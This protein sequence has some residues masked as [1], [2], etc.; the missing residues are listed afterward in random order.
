MWWHKLLAFIIRDY[1][2]E[3]SYRLAFVMRFAGIFISIATFFFIAQLFGEETIP[4]LEAY[5][6][7]Y[8][9][10]VLIGIAFSGL[11]TVGLS[12]FS[13]SIS[14]AQAQGTL[15]AM[16]VTPTKLSLIVLFSS[17][18]SFL[19]TALNVM[20]YLIIGSLLFGADFSNA[21]LVA[22]FLILALT[23]PV[24]SGIGILSASFII[25]LKRG[26][27]INWVFGSLSTLMGGTFFP[28]EVMP[29][30][31]QK[32][33][34]VFPIF[35]ALRAMRQALIQGATLSALSTDILVL[36]T[37]AALVLPLSIVAF[38]Y[39]VKQAKIDGS[40]TTY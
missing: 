1:R 28:I 23:I 18:W 17:L 29:A 25:V 26:D 10:F 21:N 3:T 20:V 22:S 13:R 8:F 24:F 11:L 2:M 36:A 19:F 39:A 33:A 40:L 15:E 5:G 14:T 16:L 38:K 7:N 32:F 27:P 6:G 9:S 37:M 35:Y 12:T 31:L 30:W 34:Y 4:Q